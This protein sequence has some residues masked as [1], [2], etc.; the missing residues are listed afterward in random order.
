VEYF[1][2]H[3]TISKQLFGEKIRLYTTVISMSEANVN[4]RNNLI[5]LYD[6]VYEGK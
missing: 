3:F 4:L 2:K 5:K 1:G 6:S